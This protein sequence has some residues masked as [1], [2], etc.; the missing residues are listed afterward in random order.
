MGYWYQDSVES[1]FS[2]TATY[3]YDAVNRLISAVATGNST[4]NLTFGYT[5]DGSNGQYGNMA[6]VQN[7]NTNGPCPQW[8]YSASTN[9]L[10]SSTGCTYDAAGNLTKD[11]STA[12]GHTY[13]W[14]AE[15]R[16][17]SVDSGSTWTFTYNAVGERVQWAYSNGAGANQQ[18]FD[19][20]G[21]WLGQVGSY[22]LVPWGPGYLLV[23]FGSETDFNHINNL[24]ST[25]V[26]TNHAG[27]AVEDMLFYPWGQVWRSW[28]SGGYN[29]A[30]MPY[31]DI[32]TNTSITRFR[33]QSPGLGRWLSP[34]PLGGDITNPQSLN[35][36]P[37]VL[38]NPT[39]L[40]DPSGQKTPCPQGA[41][42]ANPG[43]CSG[44]ILAMFAAQMHLCYIGGLC[45]PS[46]GSFMSP[47]GSDE[48][49]AIAQAP[50]MSFTPAGQLQISSGGRTST[51]TGSAA[52][53]EG[54]WIE[55][56]IFMEYERSNGNVP[57]TTG[58]GTI[59]I[60]SGTQS[61]AFGTFA[62]SLTPMKG[63]NLLATI[64]NTGPN[65]KTSFGYNGSITT[66]D[67]SGV[68][69]STIGGTVVVTA[70]TPYQMQ[71]LRELILLGL[72]L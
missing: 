64:F 45:E 30:Q 12:A 71:L 27:T 44:N 23:Y 50:G 4:Y 24:S 53:D 2:H 7:G 11:C 59:N 8:S 17:A 31:Y 55:A 56:Q 52:F 60:F 40:T 1:G 39:T 26:R 51:G 21:T 25:A 16:V 66:L 67:W 18:L 34:D 29:F 37:Y 41:N 46:L 15:G 36:Y 13:Q 48:F 63:T 19:P 14:D 69:M 9:Q 54:A 62:E 70:A 32:T 61:A 38:N 5:G 47:T 57:P 35:R 58:Y 3:G 72:G 49:D 20:S 68:T 33:L 65:P 22:D 10:S 28:G 42:A 43:Q 6:C